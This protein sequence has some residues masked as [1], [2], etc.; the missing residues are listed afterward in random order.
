MTEAGHA[1][2]NLYD[3]RG[4]LVKTMYDQTADEGG[5]QITLDSRG[6]ASGVYF[7]SL[8]SRGHTVWKRA[9]LVK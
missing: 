8:E 3:V 6:L 1:T 9:I 4:R 5:H 7:Y 2:L